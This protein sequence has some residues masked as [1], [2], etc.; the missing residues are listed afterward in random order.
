MYGAYAG[1]RTRTHD[2]GGTVHACKPHG[3]HCRGVNR[4][5]AR[6]GKYTQKPRA[7]QIYLHCRGVNRIS[8]LSG[9]TSKM[10]GTKP[11]NSGGGGEVYLILDK[12]V[13]F[14]RK[15]RARNAVDGS[16]PEFIVGKVYRKPGKTV[17]FPG[18]NKSTPVGQHSQGHGFPACITRTGAVCEIF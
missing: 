1:R 17:H 13:H 14:P 3:L 10:P 9:Q 6:Q 15:R 2:H 7:E 5:S 11:L 16:R 4:I 12:L 8:G 18:G